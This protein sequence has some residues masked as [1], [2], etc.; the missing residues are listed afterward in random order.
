[1]NKTKIIVLAWFIIIAINADAQRVKKEFSESQT[2]WSADEEMM[3]KSLKNLC[4]YVDRNKG[5]LSKDTL[6][7]KY[8]SFDYV[9]NDSD[10]GRR[11]SRVKQFDT[12]FYFFR[13]HLDSLGL[14][15]LDAKPIRFF[16]HT[17]FYKPFEEQEN[18]KQA[19][20]DVFVY[21]LKSDP[22]VPKG[23]LLFDRVSKKLIAWILLNQGGYYYYLTFRLL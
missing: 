23:S 5:R 19:S 20:Q 3:Y 16:K 21:F 8:I 13:H 17:D 10:K 6:F 9:L 18:L 22:G 4:K 1:M 12:L 7:N 14:E 15:N 2:T 11:D